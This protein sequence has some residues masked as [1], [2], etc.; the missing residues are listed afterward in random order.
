MIPPKRHEANIQEI[1]NNPTNSKQPLLK[2]KKE[3]VWGWLSYTGYMFFIMFS[4]VWFLSGV[5]IWFSEDE[6]RLHFLL[7]DF[8]TINTICVSFGLILTEI[9]IFKSPYHLSKKMKK[10]LGVIFLILTC[11]LAILVYDT[12]AGRLHNVE[13]MVLFGIIWVC[14][15]IWLFLLIWY[16]Y[17]FNK[18]SKDGYHKVWLKVIIFSLFPLLLLLL[19]KFDTIESAIVDMSGVVWDDSIE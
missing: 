19:F 12:N 8:P 5:P 15:S 3:G 6:Y 10:T 4:L 14:I 18:K 7:Y 1:L 9:T 11:L 2:S 17:Y 16:L 13:T